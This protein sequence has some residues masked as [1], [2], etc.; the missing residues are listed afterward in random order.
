[1]NAILIIECSRPS[2]IPTNWLSN[3]LP[4]AAITPLATSGALQIFSVV[5]DS[6]D[7]GIQV[8]DH[9]ALLGEDDLKRAYWLLA[10]SAAFHI[11]GESAGWIVPY[12]NPA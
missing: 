10:P 6:T 4:D 3:I 8:L 5:T 12:S 9:L 2:A 1:M 7:A 11:R